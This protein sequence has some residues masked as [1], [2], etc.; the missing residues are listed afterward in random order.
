MLR[1]IQLGKSLVWSLGGL[2]GVALAVV[3]IFVIVPSKDTT[4]AGSS[5]VGRPEQTIPPIDLAN[6]PNAP[7]KPDPRRPPSQEAQAKTSESETADPVR[8]A[9]LVERTPSETWQI[10][11]VSIEP[12]VFLFAV[13]KPPHTQWAM[14]APP[15]R[16]YIVAS[17]SLTWDGRHSHTLTSTI[18]SRGIP[19]FRLT[20]R[21]NRYFPL[22]RL[23]D[24]R[25]HLAPL[26]Q[27]SIVFGAGETKILDIV[28]LIPSQVGQVTL[29]VDGKRC[30]KFDLEAPAMVTPRELVG[31]WRRTYP[32]FH[33]LR[34]ED[35]LANRIA[36]A[37]CRTLRITETLPGV[38]ELQIPCAGGRSM[39]LLEN[40]AKNV[41][42]IKI[43]AG[44]EERSC[45]LRVIDRAKA[46]L[47]YV[48]KDE[49]AAFLFE[50]LQG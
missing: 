12:S 17:L 42:N 11:S 27:E 19:T 48:G 36:D 29:V 14:P 25:N 44:A 5:T 10:A 34:F 41:L 8:P 21:S 22:G 9:P 6:T 32:Q 50:R 4:N 26:S 43:R 7:K 45:R 47:L 1:E 49:S 40:I 13:G 46:L 30:G 38:V 33:S 15:D 35:A 28:F 23:T 24:R 18:S 39:P 37:A 31:D 20:D 3:A 2:A 16:R